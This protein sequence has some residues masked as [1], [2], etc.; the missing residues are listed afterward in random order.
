MFKQFKRNIYLILLFFIFVAALTIRFLYF[1]DNVYFAF[2]QARDAFTSLN[3]LKGDFKLIGPPSFL[4]KQLF[5]GPLILYIYAPIYYFFDK[6]PEA[7]SAFFRIW[8]ALGVFLVFSIGRVLF[9]KRIGILAALFFAFSY[10]QS[11]YALF[12]SH[13]PL[14][15]ITVLLFYLGLCLYIFQKK[16]EGAI[17]IAGGLGLSIQFHYGYAFLIATLITYLSIFRK[18]L[19]PLPNKWLLLSMLTFFIT[20]SSFV[21]AEI[22][23]R[24]LTGLIL[25]PSA[26][27]PVFSGIHLKETVPVVNRFLHDTF[28]ADYKFIPFIEIILILLV[29]QLFSKERQQNKVVFLI[30]WFIFG[31]SLY[32]LS[33]V[34][35][36]YYSAATTVSLLILVS[37]FLDK[38]FSRRNILLG[39]LLILAVIVNNLFPIL[40]YNPQGLNSDMAIQPAMLT[41]SQRQALDYMYQKS[42]GKPFAVGALTVPLNINVTW[43]YIFEWYGQKTYRYLPFWIGPTTEGYAGNLKVINAR[44][45]LPKIQFIII[46][47]TV[48][49]REIDKT[50]FFRLE[51]YFTKVIEEKD[52]GTITVQLRQPL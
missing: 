48:G 16:P 14:A 37:Y 9:N 44:S 23:Y 43:S 30:I 47:P 35:S 19:L 46:E 52:F 45:G 41:S 28:L 12:L 4:N 1:P 33:G 8:N 26:N 31:L 18:K 17:M 38:L 42:S 27:K 36:Y 25:Y 10:E 15:V 6:S 39:S 20:I 34:S 29:I 32:L 2:D 51:S 11:Q 5:P 3:I 49:I 21:L 24:F 40:H 13:H 50:N 22:K 7:V